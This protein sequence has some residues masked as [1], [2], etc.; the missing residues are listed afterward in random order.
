MLIKHF[1]LLGLAQTLPFIK[2]GFPLKSYTKLLSS[3]HKT[4]SPSY[5]YIKLV[6]KVKKKK[7]DSYCYFACTW[8]NNMMSP[9]SSLKWP[10]QEKTIEN[11]MAFN[12]RGTHKKVYCNVALLEIYADHKDQWP[13]G[14]LNC[15]SLEYEV[16]TDSTRS[17]VCTYGL[18]G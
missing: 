5:H 1:T 3:P 17:K 8:Y 6:I 14:G 15:K 11:I 12:I 18:V 13:Q 7:K 2:D 10:Y 9:S 16:V 4:L